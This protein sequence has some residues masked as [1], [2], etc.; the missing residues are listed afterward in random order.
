MQHD[1]VPTDGPLIIGRGAT[2]GLRIK[3]DVF[4]REHA[5]VQL[6]AG[7]IVLIDLESRNGVKINETRVWQPTPLADGDV[8]TVGDVSIEVELKK[9]Q[10]VKPASKP[11]DDTDHEVTRTVGFADTDGDSDIEITVQR[12]SDAFTGFEEM[13]AQTERR[14]IPLQDGRIVIGRDPRCEVV[15]ES[16]MISRLHTEVVK[17]GGRVRVRDLNSTNGTAVNGVNIARRTELASG[18]RLTIGPF[19]IDF[20]GSSLIIEPPRLGLEVRVQNL[21]REVKDMQTGKPLRLLDEVTFT[22]AP[23]SFVGLLGPSGCGKSTLMD[24]LN[25]RRR[26]TDGN[27]VFNDS[28]LYEQFDAFKAGIGYVPQEVIFHDTLP[29]GEALRYASKLRLSAD[30]SAEEIDQNIQ[31]VLETVGLSD[32]AGT[33]IRHLSGGQKKRV[34]IAIELLSDPDILFLD[35]VTSG[36]DLGTEKEMME[37]FRKLADDGKTIICITHFLE[38]LSQCDKLVCLM[39]GKLVFDGEPKDMK[40]HFEIEELRE[41]YGLEKKASPDEWH[42]R[43]LDTPQGKALALDAQQKAPSSSAA[44][45]TPKPKSSGLALDEFWLQFRVLTR[46]YVRLLTLDTK[47]LGL[48]LLFGPLIGIMLCIYAQS[49]EVP[50]E[51]DKPGSVSEVDDEIDEDA[52]RAGRT[53]VKDEVFRII[54]ESED[55]EKELA[56][57]AGDYRAYYTRQRVLLF[58]TVLAAMLL[59][60]FASVQEIVKELPIYFHE[61]F[62]KLQLAPYLLS[63]V[64]PLAVLG[65]AQSLLLLGTVHVFA[66]IDAGSFF[67]QFPIVFLMALIGTLLGLVISAGVPGSKESANIAVL[68]MIAVVIPQILYSGGLGPLDGIAEFIGQYLIACYWG[69]EALTSNIARAA[70]NSNKYPAFEGMSDLI[71]T[72]YWTSIIVLSAHVLILSVLLVLFMLKKDGPE[73]IRK[74]RTG[75]KQIAEKAGL[76]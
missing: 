35:E 25:G 31:R 4:S 44:K 64:L 70:P 47:M 52:I 55:R 48:L 74:L 1:W 45:T 53:T 19:Q 63:K 18:D 51:F 66:D 8:I 50:E 17:E 13:P 67:A 29:L 26:G 43:F 3:Q 38:S 5:R 41:V 23:R 40:Q 37:L 68:L 36:L 14:E 46:R 12:G 56:E 32:R 61:R 24:A 28:D 22:I 30:V 73:A 11:M 42:K 58:G 16:L 49:V 2:A 21:T 59:S 60:M 57:I 33:V 75:M 71:G 76:G 10:T 54:E 65:A 72:Q 62:V 7:N 9:W 34:S 39:R 27:V 15:L 20:D 6:N 69:L